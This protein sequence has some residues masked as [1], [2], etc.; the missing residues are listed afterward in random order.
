[1]VHRRAISAGFFCIFYLN[2]PAQMASESLRCRV[3]ADEMPLP[4][5]TVYIPALDKGGTTDSLGLVDLSD[6]PQGLY[7]VTA[8]YVGYFP[9][10]KAIS[11]ESGTH[12][13]NCIFHLTPQVLDEVVVTGNMRETRRSE[14]AIPVEVISSRLF[15]RNPTP[16]L[17]ESVGMLS[18]VQPVLNCNVCN[19]GDIQINGMQGVYT[20]VLLD[21]MPIVSGLG[22]VY[23]LMG[24]PNSLIDR[25][26]VVKGPAGALYGSEAMA[27]QINIIT[28][29]PQQAPHFSLDISGTS[30]GEALLDAGLKYQAGK[31]LTGLLGMHAF[32]FNNRIDRNNDGFTDV[33]LQKRLSAFHKWQWQRPGNKTAQ[34]GARYVWEDRWGG[35]MDWTK[36]DRGS[37]RIYGEHIYTNRFELFGAYQLPVAVPVFL[38]GSY[39]RHQQKSFYGNT[40]FDAVQ[41][42]AFVQSYLDHAFG[43]HQFLTGAALR[44][45]QYDDNTPAAIQTNR[46]LLPG[47]FV[48][49][50]IDLSRHSHLLGGLRL[51]WHPEHGAVWSPRMAFHQH[52]GPKQNLRMSAGSGF[53][54]VNLFTEDHAALS[55][56][57]EIVIA[58]TLDPERSWS[59]NLNYNLQIPAKSH[60][61]SLD[62]TAF[63]THFTNRILPDYDSN[64]QQIIYA[65]LDGH[66]VTRGLTLQLDYSNGLPLRINTGATFMDVFTATEGEKVQ[67]IRAPRWSGVFSANYT[68]PGSR[69][70]FDLTGNWFGPQR[71]PIV[72]QDFRPEYSPWFSIINLQISRKFKQGLECYGGIKNLLDFVPENPILRPFDPFD[73]QVDDP[74]NNPFGYTFD[75]SYNYA[76]LQGIRGFLGVRFTVL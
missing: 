38:Q 25:I 63:Y 41:D 32:G 65:N 9:Q 27:G 45:T 5:A 36:A 18:G 2:L 68:H 47:I 3:F 53:R 28:K 61:L 22:T 46:T 56:A 52:I 1:M 20:Q 6:L 21:G 34:L 49:D 24:I 57:R 16:N 55:G 72:S 30:W 62:F 39:N 29:N 75:P 66:A 73:R 12:L 54:V 58:E 15:L 14:S 13:E 44:F 51:D 4:L 70:A 23:G 8:S 59:G 33:A 60:F 31:S 64:P 74:V 26:E 19:T 10:Q 69:I 40:P 50:E 35:Q 71:L 17:F 11:V 67:Q 42:I 43:K 7:E 48:Q 37:D 76:S